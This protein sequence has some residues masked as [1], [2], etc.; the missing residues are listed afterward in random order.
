M[1][2]LFSERVVAVTLIVAC[3]IA[4]GRIAKCGFINFDDGVYITLN[5]HVREGLSLESMIWAFKSTHATNWHPLTWL[6]HMLDYELFELNPAGHHLNNLFLHIANTLLLFLLL[7]T[8]TGRFW[9][10]IAVAGLFALHPLRVESVAWVSERKDVLSAFFAMLT[11]LAY[12]HFVRQPSPARYVLT[13]LLFALGL[14]AKPMLV[15]LPF[16]LLLLDFWPLHRWKFSRVRVYPPTADQPL[17]PSEGSL[18]ISSLVFEKVPL[19]ALSAASS[20]ITFIVQN[21]GGAVSTFETISL[22]IRIANALVSYW[23]YLEKTFWPS[24]LAILYPHP[25]NHL[26]LWEGIVAGLF[27]V[28]VSFLVLYQTSQRPFLLTGWFWFL[29]M[30]VPVIGIIQVGAQ[31]HADRYTYLPSVGIFIMVV[32]TLSGLLEKYPQHKPILACGFTFVLFCLSIATWLQTGYWRTTETVFR[33]AVAVTANNYT[34][35]SLLGDALAAGKQMEM[36][37]SEYEKALKIYPRFAEAHSK[38]GMLLAGQGLGDEAI[39]HYEEALSINPRCTSAHLNIAA[40]LAEKGELEKAVSH[41]S[42]ALQIDPESSLA[43]N[44]LGVVMAK[45]E[46][47]N[48][49]IQHLT[50][51]IDI[52]PACPEPHNN[53]GRVLTLQGHLAEAANQIQLAIDL[54]PTYAEAYNNAGLICLQVGALE[55]ALYYFA[56]ALHFKQDYTKAGANL[57]LA[58]NLLTQRKPRDENTPGEVR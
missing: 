15:T 31:A 55:E 19:F 43:Q 8:A 17:S 4:F 30:L 41:Y 33:R 3:L 56:A 53:L 40:A 7:R 11:M 12:V 25:G 9:E 42:E 18:P 16:V 57:R 45:M 46:K 36:A 47:M 32:W 14:M 39:S 21:Q 50:R 38:L 20:V 44:G 27:L 22:K 10:S 26:P 1:K 6:S 13:L 24:G 48:E 34:A 35:H 58:A 51:A 49:A 2:H 29:G 54:S 52:C 23:R 5:S 28:I 37:Q